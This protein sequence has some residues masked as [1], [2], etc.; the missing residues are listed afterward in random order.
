M[1]LSAED[2]ITWPESVAFLGLL[3]AVLFLFGF[4]IAS[5]LEYRKL[6]VTGIQQEDLRQL[7][8]RYEKLAESSMD[9]QQRIATDVA[10]LRTRTASIETILRTVE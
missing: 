5:W 9:A 6:K 7:V 10:D 3:L 8:S 2:V 1:Y 4:S